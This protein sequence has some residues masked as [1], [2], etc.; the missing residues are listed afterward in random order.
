[1]FRN[2]FQ[3]PL[4]EDPAYSAWLSGQKVFESYFKSQKVQFQYRTLAF[5]L[6]RLLLQTRSSIGNKQCLE[7][8][9]PPKTDWVWQKPSQSSQR[10]NL[11]P[12]TTFATTELAL[13]Y[14]CFFVAM[15]QKTIPFPGVRTAPKQSNTPLKRQENR[16]GRFPLKITRWRSSNQEK[17]FEK[18]I[19]LLRR[20]VDIYFPCSLPSSTYSTGLTTSIRYSQ[21][22]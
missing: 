8:R 16:R 19:F 17:F 13:T 9:K 22:P 10:K 7:G 3:N 6:L 2:P 14:S 4:L 18:E 21:F 11:T 20:W 5:F 12:W 15:T 1:M